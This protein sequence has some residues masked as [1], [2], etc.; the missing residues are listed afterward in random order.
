M[1]PVRCPEFEDW[2]ERLPRREF[3]PAFRRHLE[4]CEKCRNMVEE[5]APVIEALEAAPP[6]PALSEAKLEAMSR[7]AQHAADQRTKKALIVRLSLLSL[8]SLPVVVLAN[9]LGARLGY[10]YIADHVSLMLAKTYLVTFVAVG[11]GISGLTYAFLFLIAGK[12][13]SRKPEEKTT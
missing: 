9:W 6:L 8:L 5:L 4:E 12:M 2:L 3:S 10:Y 7:A 1:N 11:A 13:R